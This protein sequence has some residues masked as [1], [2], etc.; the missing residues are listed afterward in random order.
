MKREVII[1]TTTDQ[2]HTH[3][4]EVIIAVASRKSNVIPLINKYIKKNNLKRLLPE[5]KEGLLQRGQTFG[6][7]NNGIE[8]QTDTFVLNQ[9]A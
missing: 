4:S 9:L 3:A 5:D 8:F 6:Y 7:T 1:I 2:W